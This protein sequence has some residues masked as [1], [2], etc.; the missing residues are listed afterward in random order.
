[1][2]KL[3][4][5]NN[6][7]K[8]RL[9]VQFV[10]GLI[11]KA[12]MP[13]MALYFVD[14]HSPLYAGIILSL[15]VVFNFLVTFYG[16]YIGDMFQRKSLIINTQLLVIISLIGMLIAFSFYQLLTIFTLFYFIFNISI[17]IQRPAID[18][19]LIDAVNS[20]NKDK[21]YT[22]SYWLGN[23][24][25]I[26][27][28]FIGGTFY[29]YKLELFIVAIIICILTTYLL[30][31]GLNYDSNIYKDEKDLKSLKQLLKEYSIVLHDKR[32]SLLILGNSFFILLELSLQSNVI[33]R[34]RNEFGI[35][36]FWGLQVDGT[37]MFSII[38]ITNT[39]IVIC[40]TFIINS[41]VSKFESKNM[42]KLGL[43]LYGIG[44]III[45]SNNN[46]YVLII[47]IIV[48]TIGELIYLPKFY[49][50]SIDLIPPD[51]RAK[52]S[53]FNG[54]GFNL[55]N[56][57]SRLLIVMN[58]FV[59]SIILS[60]IFVFLWIIASTIIYRSLVFKK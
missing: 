60:M 14:F 1:M 51:K 48:S 17:S 41:Y 55:A 13:F 43:F 57:L 28:I 38:T 16:G 46:F 54:L 10:Q 4:Y 24:S 56:L 23:I 2:N 26:L 5:Y 40:C 52:Y 29:P 30:Y 20:E 45:L 58:V 3:E 47:C 35:F 32:Y 33:V 12:I 50:L 37:D 15:T 22:I 8:L 25:S 9:F 44:Y 19:I 21:V 7:I 34:L 49:S 18:A 31:K 39:I 27:G 59:P 53:A 6:T 42:L 11:M 36:N